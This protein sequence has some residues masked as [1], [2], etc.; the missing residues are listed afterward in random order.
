MI[1][2]KGIEIKSGDI[3]AYYSEGDQMCIDQ[4]INKDGELF[5][6]GICVDDRNGSFHM[7]LTEWQKNPVELHYSKPDDLT[8][9]DALLA[10]VTP[11]FTQDYFDNRT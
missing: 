6:S 10:D 11:E 2:A 7:M 8:I 4:I 3:V 9:L 1:D 5:T